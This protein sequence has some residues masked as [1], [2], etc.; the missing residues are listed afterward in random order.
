MELI[1][2]NVWVKNPLPVSIEDA[3]IETLNPDGSGAVEVALNH[4]IQNAD[5]LGRLVQH[6]HREG[7]INDD[8]VL[9]MLP[10]FKEYKGAPRDT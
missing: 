2:K 5:M 6:L 7:I 9:A 3:V 8:F 1:T 4:G 10:G